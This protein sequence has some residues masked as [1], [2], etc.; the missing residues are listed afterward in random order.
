MIGKRIKSIWRKKQQEITNC[1]RKCWRDLKKIIERITMKGGTYEGMWKRKTVTNWATSGY[2]VTWLKR[3]I[4]KSTRRPIICREIQWKKRKGRRGWRHKS[5]QLWYWPEHERGHKESRVRQLSQCMR[6][7]SKE[8][9][10]E[11]T[12]VRS[13]QSKKRREIT[14]C[15]VEISSN[16]SARQN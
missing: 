14:S 8:E 15:E 11:K 9:N 13:I 4:K 2:K 12:E 6:R 16:S 3:N 10:N 7:F 1:E 5:V